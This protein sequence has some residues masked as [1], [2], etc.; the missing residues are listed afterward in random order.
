VTI[1]VIFVLLRQSCISV[2]VGYTW[3]HCSPKLAGVFWRV[4][5]SVEDYTALCPIKARQSESEDSEQEQCQQ[6]CVDL[7]PTFIRAT[8][9]LP[10]PRQTFAVSHLV[11]RGDIT[12]LHYTV[13]RRRRRPVVFDLLRRIKREEGR[14]GARSSQSRSCG[15]CRRRVPRRIV[16]DR[17]GATAHV[18]AG[19]SARRTPPCYRPVPQVAGR[20]RPLPQRGAAAAEQVQRQ[21]KTAA[22]N[23]DRP[24]GA[25]RDI[26]RGSVGHESGLSRRQLLRMRLQRLRTS[27]VFLDCDVDDGDVLTDQLGVAHSPPE[28]SPWIF[29][30]GYR[31][32]RNAGLRKV[33]VR[34][35]PS[36]CPYACPVP[37]LYFWWS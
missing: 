8:S 25:S 35:G 16:L 27:S 3:Y 29:P 7:L 36:G 18:L 22:D 4:K 37:N 23:M 11:V 14:R 32:L 15:F 13:A 19:L 6:G 20:A 24:N 1:T 31:H 17:I 9:R 10:L 12:G 26:W 33:R 5:A 21:R 2:Y 34:Y 28:V 30:P